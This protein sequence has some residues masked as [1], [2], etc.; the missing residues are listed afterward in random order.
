MNVHQVKIGD[1]GTVSLERNKGAIA[2]K[3]YILG[4][5]VPL[6]PFIPLI[7]RSLILPAVPLTDQAMAL[8][9]TFAY[10]PGF[11]AQDDLNANP[12]VIGPVSEI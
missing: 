1:V 9:F 10:V 6:S 8:N 2:L 3:M 5:P 11:F 12:N 7:P 4:R